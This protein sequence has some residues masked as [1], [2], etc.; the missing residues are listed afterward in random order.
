M[1]KVRFGQMLFNLLKKYR[2]FTKTE[3]R[4]IGEKFLY[5]MIFVSSFFVATLVIMTL[6]AKAFY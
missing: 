1:S 4:T 5:I 3:F 6:G 2:R